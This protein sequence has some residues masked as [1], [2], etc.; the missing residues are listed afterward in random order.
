LLISPY[1]TLAAFRFTG[2]ADYP[3]QHLGKPQMGL[4]FLPIPGVGADLGPAGPDFLL[5]SRTTFIYY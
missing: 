2:S 3:E 5:L 4:A 1:A